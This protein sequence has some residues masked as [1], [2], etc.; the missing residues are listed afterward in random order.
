MPM[1]GRGSSQLHEID[2]WE[3]GVG[4]L[5]YPDETMQ[6]ASHAVEVDGDVWLFDPVDADGLDDLLAEYGDVAGVAIGLD[7][8]KRDAATIATRHEVPVYVASWMTGVADELDAPVERFG[9]SLG[10]SGFQ[11]FRIVDRAVPPWQE[12]GFFHKELGT[13]V[14]PETVGTV[15]YF[16]APGERLGVH[17]ML[18]PIPPRRALYGYD[19]DRLLVG[20]GAG[21]SE[22][23]GDELRTALSNARTNLP[24]AYMQAFKSM[25]SN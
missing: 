11:T 13:L 14:V 4:W 16:C 8:H 7:R 15:G 10:D 17:P 19:P 2:R 1:K 21:I 24:S 9:N 5:A 18:R 22:N 20:H 12:V 23:A 3:H 25:L 6:R